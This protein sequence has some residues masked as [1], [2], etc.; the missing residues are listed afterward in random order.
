MAV[1]A[2]LRLAKL[3]GRQDLREKAEGT[4]RL[5]RGVMES[6]PGAA[7]QMLL[8]YD[9]HLGPVDEIAIVG[10]PQHD[11]T[12]RVLRAIHHRFR[13]HQVVALKSGGVDASQ[14]SVIPLLAGKT[15]QG[16]VMTYLCRDFTCQ[17][18]LVGAVAVEA[19]MAKE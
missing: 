14:E 17:E 12:R 8:A 13:P 4:L 16:P 3:T 18:P 7:S 1:T 5:F 10:D 19:V 2:L 15:T 11:E 6:M 9:F